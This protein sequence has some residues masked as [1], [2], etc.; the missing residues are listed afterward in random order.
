MVWGCFSSSGVG[1]LHRIVGIMDQFLYRDILE[2]T[3]LPFAKKKM[4][5]GWIFQQDNDPKHTAKRVKKYLS[6]K[7]VRVLEWP[8]QSPDLNP[9]EN[10]WH[11]VQQ[12]IRGKKFKTPD[13]LF[14]ALQTEW[15]RLPPTYMAKLV[16]SM[17]R[18]CQ[19]V[20][21]SKGAP[22]KY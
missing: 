16:E 6:D 18:R 2:N 21:K 17:P 9:I 12:G 4:P 19:A 14:A 8:A 5:R 11:K 13:V 22:T 3:M 1:P 10:L 15:S 7:K 20:I